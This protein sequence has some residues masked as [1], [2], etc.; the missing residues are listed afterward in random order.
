MLAELEWDFVSERTKQG[1]RARTRPHTG[2]AQG[3]GATPH[4]RRRPLHLHARG[5]LLT[6]IMDVHL[7]YG[8]YLSLKSHL[9]M[10]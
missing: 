2:K 1:L 8:K 5:G 10:E 4:I 3:R 9:T 7:K 6:T